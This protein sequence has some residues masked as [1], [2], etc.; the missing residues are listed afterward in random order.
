MVA[1]R[2][3]PRRSLDCYTALVGRSQDVIYF[4]KESISENFDAAN[5]KFEFLIENIILELVIKEI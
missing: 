5:W 2:F 4:M 1:F 3:P